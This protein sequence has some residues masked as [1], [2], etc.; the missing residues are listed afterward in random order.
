M[1]ITWKWQQCCVLKAKAKQKQEKT[2]PTELGHLRN[3]FPNGVCRYCTASYNFQRRL[4]Y[5]S[6]IR[7]GSS[8]KWD[9]V[10][11]F[12]SSTDSYKLS[13]TFSSASRTQLITDQ[14]LLRSLDWDVC[15]WNECSFTRKNNVLYC[16]RPDMPFVGFRGWLQEQPLK[17][18]W[19]LLYVS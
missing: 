10:M 12:T 6:T 4:P 5:A 8:N 9:A 11:T 18:S 19:V 1:E 2:K 14:R 16:R 17:I 3:P 7:R 15:H 13:W